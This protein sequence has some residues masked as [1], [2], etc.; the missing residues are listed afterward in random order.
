MPSYPLNAPWNA[1]TDR[2]CSVLLVSRQRGRGFGDL[3]LAS[4]GLRSYQS[5]MQL[6]AR[7]AHGLVGE[8]SI[9]AA[10]AERVLAAQ[11]LF[12]R[13]CHRLHADRTRVLCGAFAGRR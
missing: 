3:H 8:G 12:L 4:V 9:Q 1:I 11:S 6:P 10:P 2:Y 7:R 5:A 13:R